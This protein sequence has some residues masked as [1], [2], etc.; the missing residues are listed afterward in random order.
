MVTLTDYLYFEVNLY[1]GRH[2]AI[3]V[4]LND[5][6]YFE[7]NQVNMSRPIKF[8]HSEFIN[9][10]YKLSR[11]TTTD[12]AEEVGCDRRTALM[13]L[14]FLASKN[15]IKCEKW[16]PVL[17][18]DTN[19][20]STYIDY[21]N[22]LAYIDDKKHK[23]LSLFQIENDKLEKFREQLLI[24]DKKTKERIEKLVEIEKKKPKNSGNEFHLPR[25]E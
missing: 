20:D 21:L 6:L 24:N 2:N 15:L 13:R 8:T 5:Y 3:F 25:L 11:S 1:K 12:I 18:W 17:Y 22:V 19:S 4:V 9:A 23:K 16:G 10:V 7:V 14:R